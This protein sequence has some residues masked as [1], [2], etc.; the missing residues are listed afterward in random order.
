MLYRRI[1]LINTIKADSTA[2]IFMELLRAIIT[3]IIFMLH[4]CPERLLE[5]K[6]VILCKYGSKILKLVTSKCLIENI[7]L[8]RKH[9][10]TNSYKNRFDIF[11]DVSV[12][13][14]KPHTL[15]FLFKGH[16][17]DMSLTQR[18]DSI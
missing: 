8:I 16:K 9:I 6:I 5:L 14:E 1:W 3:A 18:C 15:F 17:F 2:D 4:V 11:F 7:V 10:L 12:K 13:L